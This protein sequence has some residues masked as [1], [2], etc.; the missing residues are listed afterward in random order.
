MITPTRMLFVAPELLM[1]NRVLRMDQKKYP[2]D[3]FLRVVFRD[4]DG[5]PV[6]ATNVG[7]LLIDRFIGTKL[8]QGINLASMWINLLWIWPFKILYDNA[9]EGRH[10]NY[11]GSSNSQMRD[12]GCYFI[13]ATVEEIREFRTKLGSFKI[14]SAPKMMSRLAQCFTQARETGIELERR[15]YATAYD[16]LGGRDSNQEPYCFSDGVGKISSQT[17]RELSRELSLEECTPSC[18]QVRHYSF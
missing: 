5:Q 13:N 6:H 15:F 1:G 2:L 16:Y 7:P 18:F 17:A 11:F 4:D 3:K 8:R 9:I 12:N 14:Q 10:F